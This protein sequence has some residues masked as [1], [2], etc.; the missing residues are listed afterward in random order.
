MDICKIKKKKDPK[1][2][3]GFQGQIFVTE[4]GEIIKTIKKNKDKEYYYIKLVKEKITKKDSIFF[5]PYIKM[6]QCKNGYNYYLMKKLDGD[7]NNL[8]TSNEKINYK[9][10]LLQL[11]AGIYIINH[12]L[13]IFH[14]DLFARGIIKNIM[15]LKN[16]E[17]NIVFEKD[18]IKFK[19][20]SY[21][22][23]IIDFGQTGEHIWEPSKRY[24]EKYFRDITLYSEVFLTTYYFFSTIYKNKRGDYNIELEDK[25][26][27]VG[28]RLEKKSDYNLK[29]FD[30][31]FIKHINKNFSDF[32]KLIKK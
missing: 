29:L 2:K 17:K 5:N 18:F 15:F 4:K 6:K 27:K 28:L 14:N 20:G 24:K 19:I 12:K 13:K 22:V 11:M 16:Q 8:L 1:I 21:I 32:M 31:L 3:Q 23:K 26:I 9:N 10:I 7:L 30:Q 25:I